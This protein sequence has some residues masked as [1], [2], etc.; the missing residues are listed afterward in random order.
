M[1]PKKISKRRGSQETERMST[2]A[3]SPE[4]DE[5]SCVPETQQA[6]GVEELVVGVEDPLEMSDTEQDDIGLETQHESDTSDEDTQDT[7]DAAA[8]QKG[9]GTGKGKANK[10]NKKP[11]VL[12]SAEQEQKL[13]DFLHDNEI[14][15]LKHLMDYKDRSKREAVWAKF[16]EENNLDKDACPKWFQGQHILF[17]K[18]THMKSGQGEP[19]MT[20]RQKWTRDNFDFLIDQ[21][22]LLKPVQQWAHHPDGG[23]CI[24][25]RSRI[26]LVRSYLVTP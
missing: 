6:A 18:V 5:L 11:P 20:E 13:V 23:L 26:L 9:K 19:V 24:W 15:Y 14:L 7:Q 16:C 25:N 1:P 17:G 22:L 2:R 10:R 8:T 3:R 4:V 12:F 21:C